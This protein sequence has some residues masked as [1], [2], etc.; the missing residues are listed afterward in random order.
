LW[1]PATRQ[2]LRSL[3]GQRR[4]CCVAFSPDGT[5]LAA[6]C[7]D[8]SITH[9]P[10]VKLW[11]ARPPSAEMA[12]ER[13][14]LAVLDFL[15]ARPLCRA[16]VREYLRDA[17][18]LSPAARQRALSLVE[19]YPEETD[20]D[21][22]YQ[23]GWAE[24]C[25]PGLNAIQYR[26]ARC[27]AEAAYRLR[28]GQT[29]YRTALGAAR[30]RTARYREAEATLTQTAGL[31]DEGLAFLALAQYRAGRHKE[32]AATLARLR[33]TSA[34]QHGNTS[35]EAEPLRREAEALVTGAATEHR[36]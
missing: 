29:R 19:H 30:Y 15:F 25:Q 24:L 13:E 12:V 17:A 18:L 31:P 5:R 32:A 1:D 22:Y 20:P 9:E 14:A 21:R 27:Q 23:A 34:A 28:P 35:E 2:E 36:P 11:D 10:T 33:V 8:N 6:G 7:Q 4:F 26:F 3:A 16:D